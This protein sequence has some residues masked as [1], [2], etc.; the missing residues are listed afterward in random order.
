MK[1]GRKYI[2]EIILDRDIDNLSRTMKEKL[3][4]EIY[5]KMWRNEWFIKNI[6]IRVPGAGQWSFTRYPNNANFIKMKGSRVS[7][8]FYDRNQ[9]TKNRGKVQLI[10][11]RLNF[12]RSMNLDKKMFLGDSLKTIKVSVLPIIKSEK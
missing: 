5:K 2:G 12:K 1:G 8:V 11:A 7:V 4:I 6:E 3:E 10:W 9:L